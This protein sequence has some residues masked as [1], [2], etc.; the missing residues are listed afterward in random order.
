VALEVTGNAWEIARVIEPHVAQVL[1]VSPTDTGIRQARAKTDRLDART[2]AKLLA[3]GSLE[4]LW[5]PDERTR[6][7]RRRLARRS[8]LVKARTRA[9]NEVHAALIRRLVPKP[10]V[11]DL[12]GLAGRRWLDGLEL[13][14]E[15]RETIDGCLRQCPPSGVRPPPRSPPRRSRGGRRGRCPSSD[16]PF[17]ANEREK[18]WANDTDGFV[19]AAQPGK[20]QG[21]PPKVGLEA[22]R[23]RNG[24]PSLR[25][26]RRPLS[27][28]APVP[29]SGP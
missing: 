19:L 9:K 15:E 14:A 29:V 18:R 28:Q 11:S 3:T 10:G 21:R 22:H 27:Q 16:P 26:P 25:S 2:L 6:A 12:F 7:M 17:V 23:A 20:S 13:P 1:V 4:G 24:L 5:L 8:Q